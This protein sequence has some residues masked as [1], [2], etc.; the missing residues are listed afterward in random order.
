MIAIAVHCSAPYAATTQPSIGA[1]NRE[2]RQ[3]ADR[4]A[5]C[6][7]KGGRDA[8]AQQPAGDDDFDGPAPGGRKDHE[9]AWA[10][11]DRSPQGRASRCR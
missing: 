11:A 10:A 6:R 3:R 5:G 8:S 2:Q 9:L 7:R 4:H 1:G